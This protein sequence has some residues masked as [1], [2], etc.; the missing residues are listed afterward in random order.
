MGQAI[1]CRLEG[2][3]ELAAS[4]AG[5]EL[6]RR[7]LPGEVLV[8]AP[9]A[10]ADPADPAVAVVLYD[11]STQRDLNLNKEIVHDFCMQG[12]FTI[13]QVNPPPPPP[14]VP[15]P[16]RLINH[17]GRLYICHLFTTQI[18]KAIQWCV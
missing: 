9:G 6:V 18:C 15:H 12:A 1:L 16:R 7:R 14:P 13:T 3:E 2:A 17:K 5:A 8:A 10:R 11:T 4:E